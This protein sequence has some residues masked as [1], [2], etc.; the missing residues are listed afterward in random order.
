ML[1]KG[2]EKFI[3]VLAVAFV[4]FHVYTAAF[5]V[6]PGIGQKSIHLG[7]ILLAFYAMELAE[8]EKT[9]HKIG[10]GVMMAVSFAGVAY[11]TLEYEALQSRIGITKDADVIFGLLL[12]I[13]IFVATRKRLGLSLVVVTTCFILYGFFG[14]YFPGFLN[15]PGMGLKRFINVAYLTTDGIFGTPLYSSAV[16]IVL[17]VV[18]G[19]V[20]EETGIGDYFTD[21]A[22]AAFGKRRGGPAKVAVIASGFFGSISGSVVGN[23]VGTGTFT[24]PLMK[25]NGFE[26]ETAGAV[27][28]A[29]STGGQIM[30]PI[31]GA[32]A[33]VLADNLGVPYFDVVKAAAIPAI[34][35]YGALLLTVDIY[36][37][38]HNL[39]GL[40]ASELPKF[41]DLAKRF[42]LVTPILFLVFAF[43]VLNLTVTRAGLYTIIVTLI[44]AM[45]NKNSRLTPKKLVN[46]CVKSIKS[47]VPVAIA[48]SMAGLVSAVVM[49]SG[50]GFRISSALV[51]VANG[52][53]MILLLLTMVVSLIM[54]MGVPTT[55]AYLMLAVLVAPSLAQMGVPPIAGHLFIF[56]FGIISAITPPVALAAYAGAGLAGCSPNKTGWRAFR[57]AIAGFILP[58]LFVYN[59]VLLW[60]GAW[61][62]ILLAFVTAMV[63]VYSLAGAIEGFIFSW[64]INPLVRVILLA[65]ALGLLIPGIVTDLAGVGCLA[66]VYVFYKMKD[67]R[68][69]VDSAT[70]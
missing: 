44:V 35:Y 69:M 21:V 10:W 18:L 2:M 52:N 59:P 54:G 5:G 11:I 36:A 3:A 47:A 20:L 34:L 33:F 38:K 41:K 17:F 6:V 1:K 58:Y 28:A 37:H 40:D 16:Y 30:P 13:A 60:Q 67:K 9:L 50:L 4:A 45:V 26:P 32:T 43:A 14:M 27:E 62:E 22:T 61:Y 48:C 51:D 31:M 66:A 63:G 25:R 8:A 70:A 39:H 23:V 15:H 46:I 7:F 65:G 55:A 56:Y 19:A 24:I 68:N 42:Y 12:I 29:A 57:L 53:L 64:Q 49:G